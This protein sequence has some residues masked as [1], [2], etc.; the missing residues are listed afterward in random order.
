MQAVASNAPGGTLWAKSSISGRDEVADY[1]RVEHQPLYAVFALDRQVLS[2]AVVLAGCRMGSLRRP[3]RSQPCTS[4]WTRSR[5][6]WSGRRSSSSSCW[7]R[8]SAGAMRSWRLLQSQ[9]FEALGQVTGGVAHDFN[10]LIGAIMGAL[11]MLR[12]RVNDQSRSSC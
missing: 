3:G 11:A 6:A 8:A 10:N 7:P 1:R 12:K 5:A 4:P 2:D 9:K